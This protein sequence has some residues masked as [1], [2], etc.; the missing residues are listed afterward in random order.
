M[1]HHVS[2]RPN[3]SPVVKRHLTAVYVQ[4][5]TH[6]QEDAKFVETSDVEMDDTQLIENNTD[7]H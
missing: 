6:L 5:L 1:T 7:T 3:T 4:H 2:S